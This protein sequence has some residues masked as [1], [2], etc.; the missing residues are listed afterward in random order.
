MIDRLIIPRIIKWLSKGKMILILG[1]RQVGKS[2]LLK[3][4]EEALQENAV[5]INGDNPEDRALLQNVN[6]RTAQQL[7][8]PGQLVFLDEV[9]RIPNAGLCL[10]IIYD[11]VNGIRL[12]A[13][14]S[15]AL[16]LTDQ[17]K[18]ALT[19]RK[20]E[21]RLFPLSLAELETCISKLDLI[22]QLETR[23]LFGNYPEVINN[24]GDEK[25]ILLQ[26][27]SDYLFKDVFS[28]IGLRKPLQ[29]EKLVQAIALQIGNQVSNREL[30]QLTGL[31][32]GTV[33]RYLTLLEEAFIIFRL[34]SFARNLRNELKR[35]RKIYFY[36]TGIRNAL[37]N[38]FQPF[39]L[40]D[41]IG[42]LWENFFISERLKMHHYSGRYV[43][44]YFWRTHRQ[45]E[46]DLVE[47]Q[48]GKLS[49]FEIKWNPKARKRIP[50]IFQ[51]SYPEA[52]VQWV[53]RENFWQYF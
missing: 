23:I 49:A 12:V 36:D 50:H 4:L 16:E 30:S 27:A 18:E 33:E 43:N 42:V 20:M 38:R 2:T 37:I 53:H 11:H 32:N 19:G 17:I 21:F 40:R 39:N 31:D 8:K 13:T 5:W 47:E 34:P 22:K 44:M 14:G 45:Q 6:S 35:S 3:Q 26:L 29:L 28:M 52:N 24:P 1:A 10:K 46:L 7:F 51:K 48:E 41:D 9:Q 25:E 15:S